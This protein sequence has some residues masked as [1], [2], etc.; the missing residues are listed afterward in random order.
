MSVCQLLGDLYTLFDQL[1]QLVREV[2]QTPL[3]KKGIFIVDG[4][5]FGW[6]IERS[7]RE[8]MTI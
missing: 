7:K 4:L 8:K 2:L 1:F 6:A 3:L 5:F